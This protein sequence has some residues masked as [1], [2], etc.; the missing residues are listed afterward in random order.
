MNRLVEVSL[1]FILLLVLGMTMLTFQGCG[2]YRKCTF[3]SGGNTRYSFE[4]PSTY[5]KES[6]DS[7]S[8]YFTSV[9]LWLP[10]R[11][12]AT[13]L[14]NP[15]IAVMITFPSAIEI[16]AK[17]SLESDLDN[18]M[19]LQEFQLLERSEI[20]VSGI[21]AEQIV[22]SWLMTSEASSFE[23]QIYYIWSGRKVY[24]NYEGEIWILTLKS[25]ANAIVQ[26][27]ADFNHFLQTFRILE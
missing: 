14:A 23:P 25:T 1:S 12:G 15:S 24:F 27:N 2:E 22:F 9:F 8:Q 21:Q 17:A 10:G 18:G 5:R 19:N 13:F 26:A 16:N 11:K 4:Y 3:H 7:A 20:I 6:D